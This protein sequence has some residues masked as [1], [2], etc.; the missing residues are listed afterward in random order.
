MLRGYSTPRLGTPVNPN[1]LSG[2]IYTGDYKIDAY[3][4][5]CMWKAD[6]GE[7]KHVW[8]PGPFPETFDPKR[9]IRQ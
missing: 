8:V 7:G 2:G 1:S 4:G 6:I 9:E 3:D 5:E